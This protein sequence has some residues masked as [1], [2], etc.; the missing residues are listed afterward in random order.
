MLGNEPNLKGRQGIEE[1]WK[2]AQMLSVVRDEEC[3]A[4]LW[5]KSVPLSDERWDPYRNYQPYAPHD[6]LYTP[7]IT[8]TPTCYHPLSIPLADVGL[9]TTREMLQLIVPLEMK[10]KQAVDIWS[11]QLY[12]GNTFTNFFQSYLAFQMKTR[13]QKP[14]LISEYGC[15]AMDFRVG[16]GEKNESMQ[17]R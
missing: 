14:A 11:F 17:A 3:D 12:R 2:L 8:S 1:Y 6:P 7:T 16:E 15:D 4:S 13:T 5:N 10:Y 9:T